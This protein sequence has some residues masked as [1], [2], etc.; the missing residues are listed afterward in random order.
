MGFLSNLF[1]KGNKAKGDAR[2]GPLLYAMYEKVDS[3]NRLKLKKFLSQAPSG[4]EIVATYTSLPIQFA[5]TAMSS[6]QDMTA[7][8]RVPKG[9]VVLGGE[10]FGTS[11]I[12][13]YAK[14]DIPKEIFDLII[15]KFKSLPGGVVESGYVSP[16]DLKELP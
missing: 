7:Q 15:L 4:C 8:K 5:Q 16:N 11:S 14:G 10:T 3:E 6:L 12:I 1:G 2:V 13:L 9:S